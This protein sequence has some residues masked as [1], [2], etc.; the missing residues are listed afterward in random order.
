MERLPLFGRRIYR[1][2]R[3]IG[4]FVCLILV[5]FLLP[6]QDGRAADLTFVWDSGEGIAG[7]KLH[8]GLA[9]HSY[10]NII[11][12]GN[13]QYYTLRIADGPTYY[14]ALTAYD[15]SGLESDYS[16]EVVYGS[17]PC[18]YTISPGSASVNA[19]GGSGSVSVSAPA[20]CS[21]SASSGAAWVT[22]TSGVTGKGNGKVVY[23]TQSNTGVPR[24]AVSTIAGQGFTLTQGAPTFLITASAGSGGSIAPAGR[25]SVAF[26]SDQS[27]A[28]V[29]VAGYRI[30]GVSVDGSPA[31][32]VG[33]YTFAAIS[34]SHSISALF[35]PVSA[36]CHLK[37][38]TTGTGRGAVFRRPAG[39]VFRAGTTVTMRAVS[40][41]NS[42]FAGWS[43]ACSGTDPVCQVV[44]EGDTSVEAGFGRI[45]RVRSSHGPY[46]SI[47]PAGFLKVREGEPLS[48]TITPKEGY[49]IHDVFVDGVSVGA[50]S[51]YAF[52]EVKGNHSITAR[53]R[54]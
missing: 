48:F 5:V 52:A 46:G 54:K 53:F 15:S 10:S 43:G 51:S 19:G 9:S 12:M 6:V 8:Y 20:G 41:F 3:R 13:V 47:S 7:Y 24:T 37:I 44:I 45:Y 31:G 17:Q 2:G 39:S 4:L 33:S 28:I 11:D 50:V 26:G 21:W 42:W 18:S 35:A 23:S 36:S 16:D 32:E 22:I 38:T 14:F 40:T 49:L 30:K 29:P 1:P 27:F 25:V 34:S